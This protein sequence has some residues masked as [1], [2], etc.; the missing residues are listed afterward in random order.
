[1]KQEPR[2]A[3]FPS[4]R[5]VAEVRKRVCP[6]A[7]RIVLFLE[8]G[9]G[10]QAEQQVAASVFSRTRRRNRSIDSVFIAFESIQQHP[11]AG[12]VGAGAQRVAVFAFMFDAPAVPLAE[13]MVAPVPAVL[14]E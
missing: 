7:A 13:R 9:V 5:E 8:V 12:V 14:L 4:R 10:D 6:I 1:M 3:G 11:F 2:A